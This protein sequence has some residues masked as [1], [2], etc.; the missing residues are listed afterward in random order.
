MKSF[1]LILLAVASLA[2]SA[3]AQDP[4]VT[5]ALG[6]IEKYEALEPDLAAGDT[7]TANY[8][9]NQLGWAGKRL[10]AVSNQDDEHWIAAKRR[11]DVLWA[12]IEAKAGA[13]AAAPEVGYDFDALV[14][15]NK[16]IN[17]AYENL[18]LLSV[19]HLADASREKSIRKELA[20][21]GVRLRDFPEGD[22]NVEIVR[23]NL[24]NFQKLFDIGMAQLEADRARAAE[25]TARLEQLSAKYASENRP[26][27][28]EH[29]FSEPQIRSWAA[30]M[31]RWRE[32]EIPTDLA[33]LVE[34]SKNSVV[35]QQKV[36]S[37]YNHAGGSWVGQLDDLE[38]IVRERIASDVQ[39]GQR[40][41]EFLLETDPSDR[42]QILNRVLGKGAFDENMQWLRNGEHAVAMARVYDE[43][44]GAPAVFGPTITDPQQ[45]RPEFPDRDAQAA[46]VDRAITHLKQLA[47]Q[48]LDEVR[49][50]KAASTDPELL[51]IAEATLRNPDYEVGEWKALVINLDRR[52]Q[53]RREAW[54]KP[55]A[56]YT[57]LSFYE[58]AWE[59]FQ[60]TTVE[61]HE[62]QLWL[63]SNR[64]KRYKSGD[65]T[66]PVGRWIL[67]RRF[68]LTPILPEHVPG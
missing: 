42:N 27:N 52:D 30:D 32:Q 63:F 37:L 3:S 34:A 41:A 65:P 61:E 62:G 19:S 36:S 31:R 33:W 38:K 57:T 16:A 25:I 43:T 39:E 13:A 48:A 60:V 7:D 12:K 4:L 15:L 46:L 29:P 47:V 17:A 51:A 55:G 54:L 2:V 35:N 8:Y 20:D 1:L 14:S 6:R 40:V 68:E 21:F 10:G 23:G 49:L 28:L 5:A 26:G 44:M 11:Y 53:V 64:L 24:A 18:K 59:E 58:Y 50:P 66:T 9:L 45:P 67:S 22:E 56:A